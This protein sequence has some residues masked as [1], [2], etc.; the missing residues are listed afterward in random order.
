MDTDTDCTLV[1]Q[2][3]GPAMNLDSYGG[4]TF[5]FKP[6]TLMVGTGHLAPG[7]I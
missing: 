7:H 4:H 3:P 6:V 1:S 5:N 2:F